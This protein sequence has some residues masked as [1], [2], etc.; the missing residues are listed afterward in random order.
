MKRPPQLG[1]RPAGTSGALQ[2]ERYVVLKRLWVM[3]GFIC[4]KRLAC[5]IRVN[6]AVLEKFE[7]LRGL[8]SA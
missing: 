6:L 8:S 3:F 2:A 1:A 7:E 5:A 4:G